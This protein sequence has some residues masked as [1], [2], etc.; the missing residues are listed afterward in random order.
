M[1]SLL[2]RSLHTPSP[3]PLSL[4][5]HS[6]MPDSQQSTI[7]DPV[8]DFVTAFY[9]D[10]DEPQSRASKSVSI[11]SPNIAR[12]DQFLLD[13]TSDEDEDGALYDLYGDDE[14]SSESIQ[15]HGATVLIPSKLKSGEGQTIIKYVRDDEETQL[16]DNPAVQEI[17]SS[18]IRQ[19]NG[20]GSSKRDGLDSDSIGEHL[21]PQNGVAFIRTAQRRAF[22]LSPAKRRRKDRSRIFAGHG[23]KFVPNCI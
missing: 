1:R 7:V 18:N 16:A 15:I 2:Y 11:R 22:L 9:F 3:F 13:S 23:V 5:P 8:E 20:S 21:K 19:T 12:F 10:P 4:L 6:Q 17:S 14:T